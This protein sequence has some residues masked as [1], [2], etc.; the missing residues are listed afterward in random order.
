MMMR[1]SRHVLAV[2]KALP[3]AASVR[4]P[5]SRWAQACP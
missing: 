5:A 3:V 2:T 1:P 4:S